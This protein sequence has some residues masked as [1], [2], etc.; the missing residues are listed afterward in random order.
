MNL[1]EYCI[2]TTFFFMLNLK[3]S[4]CFSGNHTMKYMINA[5]LGCHRD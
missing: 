2:R 1:N 3:G 4:D 5:Y